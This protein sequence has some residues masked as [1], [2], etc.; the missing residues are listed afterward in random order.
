MYIES[1]PNR[2]PPPAVLL[3]ESYRDSNGK[4]KKRT[5]ANLTCLDLAVIATL[6]R[7]LKGEKMVAAQDAFTIISS[8]AHGHVQAVLTAM[9][10]LTLS[11]IIDS[12]S[13]RERDLVLSMTGFCASKKAAPL[14][15][16]FGREI[17]VIRR[18]LSQQCKNSSRS[19]ACHKSPWPGIE[20]C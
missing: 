12:K 3:R 9:Q 5:L 6:K 17:Q 15:S 13:C 1:I 16:V 20:G 7:A 2:N 4:V 10:R 14:L 19:T 11:S 18:H 8:K